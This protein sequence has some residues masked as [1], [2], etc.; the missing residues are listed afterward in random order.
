MLYVILII[1]LLLVAI[2]LLR[3]R[4]RFELSRDERLLFVGLGRS[5]HEQDFVA[6]VGWIK[7]FGMRVKTLRPEEKKEPTVKSAKKKKKPEKKKT[8]RQRSIKDGLAMVPGVFRALNNYLWSLIRS[9]RVEELDGEIEAGFDSP[10]TTGQAYGYYQ[11]A[12]ATVPSVAGR[13][14]FTPDWS[15]PSFNG[16]ARVA[17]AIPLY[18]IILRTIVLIF[19][20]PLRKLVKLA[21]GRK[22]GDQDVQ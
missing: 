7:L 3:I 18:K 17:L 8:E 21:I 6:R 1:G 14:R 11:A 13:L 10:D 12:L 4:V 22:K 16:S 20:L 5:G 19:K 9:V 15:G 2:T